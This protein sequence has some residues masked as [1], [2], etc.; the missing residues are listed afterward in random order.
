MAKFVRHQHIAEK[1]IFLDG[2]SGTA[3]SMLAPILGAFNGVEM[4]RH[5]LVFEYLSSLYHLK[6]IDKDGAVTIA[7][8]LSDNDLYDSMISRY[9]NFRP[10]DHTGA[11]YNLRFLRHL[12]RLFQNDGD[13]VLERIKVERPASLHMVHYLLSMIDLAFESFDN[14]LQIIEIV[15][16]PIYSIE[17]QLGKNWGERYSVDPRDFS[18]SLEDD[19]G[20]P[21]PFIANQIRDSYRDLSPVDRIVFA[22]NEME[23]LTMRSY[24]NLTEAQ[25]GMIL[26]VP[27]EAFVTDP[28]MSLERIGKF[29]GRDYPAP[30]MN[31]LLKK[32]NCPRKLSK[33]E[34]C[35]LLDGIRTKATSGARDAIDEMVANYENRYQ[36][37]KYLV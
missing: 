35:R 34:Y 18:L 23:K 14:R 3:K 32:G 11:M 1:I 2:Y 31:K 7:R 15:R 25:K 16:N 12:T 20:A 17:F 5:F 4:M 30:L 13:A 19:N 6:K 29:L 28:H 33:V 9:T 8:I 21:I 10:K 36:T 27:F 37:S 26:F 24:G 22:H